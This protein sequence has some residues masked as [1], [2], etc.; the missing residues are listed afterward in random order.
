M[1]DNIN[2]SSQTLSSECI[3]SQ[4]VHLYNKGIASD[5]SVGCEGGLIIHSGGV[6]YDTVVSGT[7][8]G[9]AVSSGGVAYDTQI[10]DYAD[11]TVSSGGVA[12]G[13]CVESGGSLTVYSGGKL[14]GFMMFDYEATC[15]IDSGA[16]LD[17]DISELS[18]DNEVLVEGFKIIEDEPFKYT[19]TVSDIQMPGTYSLSEDAYSFYKSITV[20]NTSGTELGTLTVNGGEKKIGCFNCSLSLVND[21]ELVV[22]VAAIDGIIY[23]EFESATKDITSGISAVNV[24]VSDDGLLQVHSGGVASD[25]TVLGGACSTSSPAAN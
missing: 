23:G 12:S 15:N 8:A 25:T 10:M 4:S 22:T 21:N 7:Y 2:V 13:V 1:S 24:I 19:L 9:V 5:C 14:T 16:I 18:P 11:M 17:F 3:T 20:K 6:A